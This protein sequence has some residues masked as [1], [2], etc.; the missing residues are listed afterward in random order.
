MY[1]EGRARL[2]RRA[3]AS[4]W[5]N[6]TR[7]WLLELGLREEREAQATGPE[8]QEVLRAKIMELESRRWRLRVARN[9]KLESYGRWKPKLDHGAGGVPRT[10]EHEAEEDVDEAAG[11]LLG[12]EGGDR[13]VGADVGGWAAG[14]GASAS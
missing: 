6:L 2:E 4:T 1:E 11:R 13:Q 10:R 5:C 8:W 14:G 12:A 3:N 9:T 7:K